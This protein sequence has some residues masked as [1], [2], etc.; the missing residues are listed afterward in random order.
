[1]ITNNSTWKMCVSGSGIMG[2]RGLNGHKESSGLV[3]VNGP[4][5]HLTFCVLTVSFLHYPWAVNR[6]TSSY[7]MW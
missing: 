5:E 1:M 2:E 3:L 4:A 6:I 7:M